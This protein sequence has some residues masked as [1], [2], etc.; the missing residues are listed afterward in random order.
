MSNAAS[1][2]TLTIA[3]NVAEV[4]ERIARAASRTGRWPDEVRL[5]AVTKTI[6]AARIREAVAA[7]VT[8]LAEN[9]VQEA[10][11]KIPEVNSAAAS[12]ADSPQPPLLTW[13]FIGHLQSNKARYCIDLFSLVHSVDS[14]PLAEEMGRQAVKHGKTMPVLIEV[15]LAGGENRAGSAPDETLALAERIVQVEGVALQGMMGMAPYSGSPEEARPY[16][17]RLR[18]LWERL[19]AENRQ[20]LSMGMSGDFEMAIE[21]GAT[22]VRIGTAIFGERTRQ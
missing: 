10:R 12:T 7:G 3:K 6:D 16:F 19:P 21:E 18:Q 17:K 15:N 13:H 20:T 22:L 5:V 8:E 11:T 9:Y 2:A 14:L 1:E 4:R